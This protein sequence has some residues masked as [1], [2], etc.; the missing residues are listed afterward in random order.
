MFNNLLRLMLVIGLLVV[1]P[2]VSTGANQDPPKKAQPPTLAGSWVVESAVLEGQQFDETVTR[3]MSLTLRAG[4]YEVRVGSQLDRGLYKVDDSQ[5]LK[6]IDV[7][8][9]EGV[10]KGKTFLAIYDW[11][12]EKLR[13]C[14]SL[15]EGKRPLTFKA[16]QPG[17]FLVT[18]KREVK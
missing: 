7:T 14:Y 9:V 2:L 4:R 13:I 10:N 17:Y 1:H 8:G 6:Q 12:K 5:S 3:T 16:N 11:Q 18:Y 15:T